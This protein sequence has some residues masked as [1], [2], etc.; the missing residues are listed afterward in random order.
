MLVFVYLHVIIALFTFVYLIYCVKYPYNLLEHLFSHT[1]AYKLF[2]FKAL[3]FM[4]MNQVN[5]EFILVC[6]T[7]W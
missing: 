6:V 3:C 2:L 4:V 7:L 1:H 5:D